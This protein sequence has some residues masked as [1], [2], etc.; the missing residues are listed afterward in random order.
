MPRG[1]G[2]P[3]LAVP[4]RVAPRS[5]AGWR[6]QRRRGL[7]VQRQPTG[8]SAPGPVNP[9]PPQMTGDPAARSGSLASPR[10]QAAPSRR[11]CL[12]PA[13][14]HSAS[15]H[16]ARARTARCLGRRGDARWARGRRSR[17][18]CAAQRTVA[19]DAWVPS[20]P[21][22]IRPRALDISGR[23]FSFLYLTSLPRGPDDRPPG[24]PAEPRRAVM[25]L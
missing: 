17:V 2:T 21:T 8:R 15:S 13:A 20:T 5:R 25:E 16:S 12:H 14:A 4:P 11:R 23:L 9:R 1:A 7:A 6:V 22:T 10:Q 3:A 18:S 24:T 19:A